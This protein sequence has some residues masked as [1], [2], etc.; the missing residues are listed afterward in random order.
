MLVLPRWEQRA[1]PGKGR[2]E[3]LGTGS[4][5]GGTKPRPLLKGSLG[6]MERVLLPPFCSEI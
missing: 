6:N 2:A 1:G 3:H 5:T 4:G